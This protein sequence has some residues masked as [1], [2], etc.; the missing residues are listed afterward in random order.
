MGEVERL[1]HAK[2][3]CIGNQTL[4]SYTLLRMPFGIAYHNFT[5]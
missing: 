2:D 1:A 4:G 5:L 3:A